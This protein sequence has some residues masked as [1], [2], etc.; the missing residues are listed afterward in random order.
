MIGSFLQ[1]RKCVFY[2]GEAEAAHSKVVSHNSQCSASSASP[3]QDLAT[4]K[5]AGTVTGSS[6]RGHKITLNSTKTCCFGH[7]SPLPVLLKI[8]VK[9]M[10]LL[11]ILLPHQQG[12][13]GYNIPWGEDG[14]EGNSPSLKVPRA[15]WTGLCIP[16][17]EGVPAHGKVLE[18]GE[19]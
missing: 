1:L 11:N 10:N 15:S 16:L 12:S 17:V 14:A 3:L 7:L 18:L 9:C 13:P 5:S 8:C 2:Y 4:E 6:I 19:V